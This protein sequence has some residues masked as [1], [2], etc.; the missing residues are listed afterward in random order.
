M[1]PGRKQLEQE[2]RKAVEQESSRNTA[3]EPWTMADL[4]SCGLLT[5]AIV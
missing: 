3:D 2:S 1:Q 5:C 4:L